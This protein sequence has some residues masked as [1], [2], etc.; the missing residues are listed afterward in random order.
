[1]NRP[2]GRVLGGGRDSGG[3]SGGGGGG[4][5]I[6][7]APVVSQTSVYPFGRSRLSNLST[8]RKPHAYIPAKSCESLQRQ[9]GGKAI[10]AKTTIGTDGRGE[11][12]LAGETAV[13]GK[14]KG[15]FA[16]RLTQSPFNLHC[17]TVRFVSPCGRVFSSS[18]GGCGRV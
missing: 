15:A 18:A 13:C 8:L 12:K 5:G 2:G 6:C 4:G 16:M 1:M 17:K 11:P 14:W 3:G 10:D 7:Q 9:V